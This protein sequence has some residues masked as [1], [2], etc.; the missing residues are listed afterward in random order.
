[1]FVLDS[2][3]NGPK[4]KVRPFFDNSRRLC[5]KFTKI[6]LAVSAATGES[7]RTIARLGFSLNDVLDPRFDP[8]P[9]PVAK[10][11]DWDRIA[12]R[13]YQRLGVH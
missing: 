5:M 2:L 6:D 13:R 7:V 11:L 4:L 12:R 10:F 3:S 1:M 8:K 9:T